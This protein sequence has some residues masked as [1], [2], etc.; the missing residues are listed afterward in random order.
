[1][2]LLSAVL[3]TAGFAVLGIFPNGCIT[4]WLFFLAS[5]FFFGVG[6]LG[7]Y[8]DQNVLEEK[9]RQLEKDNSSV[10]G[11]KDD[12]NGALQDCET[13]RA[14][15]Q[16]LHKR[17][18]HT[19]LQS[20]FKQLELTSHERVTIY[21]EHEKEFYLLSRYSVNPTLNA[22]HEQKFSI[23]RGVLCQ[24]WEHKER[25]DIDKCPIFSDD[26]DGYIK[27]QKEKYDYDGHSLVMKSCSYVGKAIIDAGN[28]IG[29]I[30]F[31]SD[32]RDILTEEQV[33]A[34][35]KYCDEY[36]SHM[37]QFVR[38]ALVL[39]RTTRKPKTEELTPEEDLLSKLRKLN[40]LSGDACEPV[41]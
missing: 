11:L 40:K 4:Y 3:G 6:A 26:L 34:I 13:L 18:V 14:E 24:A 27:Y 28:H 2:Y 19:W 8:I 12:L 17:L 35:L 25:I 36:Q 32:I 41:S 9:N 33:K 38:D 10:V 15:K 20:S 1:M 16:D 31:E 39:D 23:N 30:I 29:V 5:F 37:S 22:E 21:Y 7:T